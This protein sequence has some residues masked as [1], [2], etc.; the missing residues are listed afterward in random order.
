MPYS[1]AMCEQCKG[2]NE[3]EPRMEIYRFRDLVRQL[4]GLLHGLVFILV[5]GRDIW[6]QFALQNGERWETARF[7]FEC[8]I[9][10]SVFQLDA[11]LYRGWAS[12]ELLADR[13][14]SQPDP[15]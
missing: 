15:M 11:D 13:R 14:E 2:F 8:S 7:R 6:P 3:R 12:W 4:D 9:C 1:L 10:R 5:A